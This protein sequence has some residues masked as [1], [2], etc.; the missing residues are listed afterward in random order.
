MSLLLAATLSAVLLNQISW[1][2]TVEEVAMLKSSD[3]QK[4]LVEGAKKEGKLSFYTTLIVDQV[5]RPLKEAFEK[6]YPFV[7][8]EFFRGNSDRIVQRLV[9]EYQAKRY[10]VDVVDGTTTTTLV[11]RAGY[12]QKFFS[13]HLAEY[14]ADLKDAQGFWGVANLYF[15]TLGY[16]TKMVKP[17]EVPKNYEDLL[18]PR[19]KG[20]LFW[21]TGRGGGGPLFIGNVFLSMGESAGKAY[22]QKLKGQNIAQNHRQCQ[23]GPRPGHRRGISHRSANF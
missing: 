10:A 2:A 8:V 6:E 22:V 7:Q 1:A 4:I 20:Q 14:P 18:N 23:A 17:N 5:V 3:R 16:N 11:R 21:S 12:A 15:H 13:P 9:S 19:W